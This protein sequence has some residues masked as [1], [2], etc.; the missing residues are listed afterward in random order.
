MR[1]NFSIL[2]SFLGIVLGLFLGNVIVASY[3]AYAAGSQ[4]RGIHVPAQPPRRPAK[5]R[6]YFATRLP[7]GASS[8]ERVQTMPL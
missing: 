6:T 2:A 1:R 7:A 5:I 4:I 3:R 8:L